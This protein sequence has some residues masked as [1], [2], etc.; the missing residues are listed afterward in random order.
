MTRV[1]RRGLVV[2]AMA[3][4]LTGCAGLG[5]A[6]SAATI[7]DVQL[8]TDDLAGEVDSVQEQRGIPAG[9]ADA[10]LTTGVLQR[11]IITELVDQAAVAQGVVI[12]QG[13][14][15][16]ATAELAAQLG[17]AEALETAFLDSDVPAASIPQQMELSLQVQRLGATLAPDADPAGQQQAV[18]LYV[19]GFGA[20]KGVAVS[21]RFG[22]WDG[23]ALII[24]PVP[25]DLS[26]TGLE[27]D[28][29]A[30]LLPAP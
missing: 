4:A 6:G 14:I 18:L 26:T 28:P 24:G 8:S 27:T 9:S 20:E 13:E 19:T 3:L 25:S 12:T 21:P 29:L 22:T 23:G 17:G 16:T 30:E 10:A 7:G 1:M 2:A 5:E 11:L 15:D